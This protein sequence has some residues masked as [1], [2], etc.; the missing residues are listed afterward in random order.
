MNPF[1]TLGIAPSF[2]LD[3]KEL[4]ARQRKLA[5]TLHPDRYVGRP[6]GE[7]RAALGKAIEVNEAH[8]A[9]K[10]PLSRAEALLNHL[11]LTVEEGNAPQ[12]SPEL[13]METMER[14][15]ALRDAGRQKDFA[16][17]QK[18]ESVVRGEEK[19]LISEL[20]MLFE[21]L[22]KVEGSGDPAR[23]AQIHQKLGNLRYLKRFLDE[24]D[25]IMDELV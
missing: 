1:D 22:L 10:S 3:V 4:S 23:A 18:L 9:L 12:A 13:L 21:Q 14:R 11:G 20:E 25:A 8:R 19:E 7:R 24:A 15:E 17:V 16:Q 2:A 5:Q 6:A